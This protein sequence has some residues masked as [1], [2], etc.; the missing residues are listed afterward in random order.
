MSTKH[1]DDRWTKL[2]SNWKPAVS[3]KQEGY[4]KQSRP[5]KK[6]QHLRT[7]NQNQHTN[8]L[9]SETT[10]LTTAEDGSKWNATKSDFISGRLKQPTRSATPITTTTTTQPATHDQTTNTS[11]A[12]DQNEDDTEDDDAPLIF[13]Q[14]I[15]S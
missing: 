2:V 7:T 8:D 9:M 4:W 10:W 6:R 15:D 5:A 11:K 12:H 1:H 13:S 3:T 14:L